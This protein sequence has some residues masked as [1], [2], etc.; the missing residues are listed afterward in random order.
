MDTS[1]SEWVQEGF[2]ELAAEITEL[3]AKHNQLVESISLL[4]GEVGRNSINLETQQLC[5]KQIEQLTDLIHE[6]NQVLES[7]VST[8][9]QTS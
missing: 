8:P 9:G 5:A 6:I 4:W 3:A 7:P 1:R 2:N